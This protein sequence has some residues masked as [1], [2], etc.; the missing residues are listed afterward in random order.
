MQHFGL[1]LNY[2]RL[3]RDIED[4]I[5][6]PGT[7]EEQI[8]R[9]LTKLNRD[10]ESVRQ[11]EATYQR[12]FRETLMQALRGDLDGEELDY[13]LGL[14]GKRVAPGSKAPTI[15]RCAAAAI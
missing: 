1:A 14:M 15:G 11:L 8:Y 2:E 4:A 7:D 10:P 6:G 5:S 12:L 9:A 3:A 13:V